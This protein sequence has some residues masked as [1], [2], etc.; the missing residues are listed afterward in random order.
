MPPTYLKFANGPGKQSPAKPVQNRQAMKQ[1]I[2]TDLVEAY[3]LC[4]RKAFLLMAGEPNPGPH[5]YVRMTDEQA[6]AS[7]QAR[8]AILEEAGELPPGGGAADLST[9][10]KVVADA[11]LAIDSLHARCDFLT[12][13][14]EPSRLGRFGYE[15]VKVIGTCRSSRP[16]TLG[17]AYQGFVLGEV[18]RRLPA[19]GTL[20]L[21]GDRTSKVKLAARY[22]EVRRIVETLRV[23]AKA[24]AADAPSVVLN[25][26]CPSCP[27]RDACLQQAEKEDN[28]SLLDRMTPKLM[29]KHQDKGIFT[30]KQ[31]SYVYKPR[32]SR[33]KA[34]R[35]VRHSLELQALAI[36]T[37][38]VHVEH[39]PELPRGPVEL[40]VDLEGVP[41][42]DE[43]YLTGVLVCRGGE[44]EYQFFW[45]DDTTGEAAMWS[46]LVER[47]E[48]FPDA[49]V[50]HY[51]SY[52]KNAF[53]K[54][55]RRHGKGKD[56]PKRLVNV[57]SSVYGKV[58]F[59]V[60]SNGLKSL[61]RFLGAAWSDPQASGLQS[62]V[63]R[64][65]WETTRDER[66]RQSLLQYNREDCEAVRRLVDRLDQIKRDAVSDPT[67]EFANLP[68]R[69]ATETGKV[70]HGQF[71][72][73]LRSAA[74]EDSPG[75]GMRVRQRDAGEGEPRK[76]GAQ[77]G[78]QTY[79]RIIPSKANRVVRV[80]PRRKCPKGHGELFL[81][82]E[83]LAER[84]VTDLA[85]TRNG[86]RKTVTRYEGKRARCPTCDKSYE[87]PAL[88]RLGNQAF[89][90]SFQAWTVYQ[91]VVLRLPYRI[92]AQVTEH[93][94]GIGLCASSGV[95]FLRYLAGYYASTETALLQAILKSDFV[96]V[97]E[98]RISIQGVDHY[99]WVFT[100]GQHV[101][102]RMTETREADIVHEVLAG[103]KGVL[104]SDFYPGYDGVP[105]KQQKC[106]VHL[107]RDINDDLW[108]APF[109]KE[110]EA[111]AF[112]VQALLVPIL[113]T[114]DRFGLKAWHLRKFEKDV[115]QFYLKNIT[116][117]EYRSEATD[118][119]RKRF[120]R[121]RDSLFT[122]LTQD[123]IPWE[124][125][126]AERAIR[127]LAVQRN[128]SG[129]FFKRSANH[130]L[131]LLA[132]SQTCRFQGKSFLKFL[133]SKETDVD[134]FRRT[135]PVRYSY[136][137][138]RRE[139]SSTGEGSAAAE[140]G[141][142]EAIG[143]PEDR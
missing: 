67:I 84:T 135:R 27:F 98:T 23:W 59:P 102:F 51:G 55:A 19:S 4:P 99:V 8:R 129:S 94:F 69:H 85:F 100:D 124:N 106:L 108:K 45:A 29:R 49:P 16:D 117:R 92:I 36:R 133:L 78:H 21:L 74:E 72:R 3:S 90:H 116:G 10:P 142:G 132:I 34:K 26:H 15:P 103:Y 22:K 82:A 134:S 2:T 65:R 86:C 71:E 113:E 66:F 114:V 73:I 1:M 13:V 62:L 96:H 35:Q 118:T 136:A 25:K 79:Y 12:K 107:I 57:A 28:L 39:L 81:D 61:G 40:F 128:I 141:E 33:K 42:R 64:H 75:L 32:R 139:G 47:L 63:W 89:G 18:Q 60:R 43:Y 95:N 110:L 80:Q 24:P 87:P 58:Y 122:F 130:Y 38:K 44:A 77:R 30:I 68:K 83:V 5:E 101:A 143:N 93:L 115:E 41:D 7:R 105:C 53:R 17:L 104:V 91:R 138:Q 125:N 88:G 11:E 14:S 37:G 31:L 48:A 111:F 109:D 56:L 50:Y 52:E 126:M 140:S 46:A 97:D 123:G 20:V 127:Q 70:V 120:D 131:L 54:L 6:A 119:Y 9:G 76:R 121:Y 137:F 112:E